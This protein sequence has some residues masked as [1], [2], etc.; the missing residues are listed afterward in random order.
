[1]FNPQKTSGYSWLIKIGK[2]GI[3]ARGA[4]F[5][6]IGSFFLQ[7][8]QQY[9]PQKAVDLDQALEI[10]AR[11]PQGR[12]MLI[13]VALG[14]IAY[15]LHMCIEAKYR[16]FSKLRQKAKKVTIAVNNR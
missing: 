15:S 12:V 3:A 14:F 10:I 13:L 16:D 5:I 7:S 6:L 2:F 1:M 8:A 9:D 4:I 11:Q